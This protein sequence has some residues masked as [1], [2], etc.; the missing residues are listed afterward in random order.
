MMKPHAADHVI[1]VSEGRGFTA[2]VV[3]NMQTALFAIF[4]IAVCYRFFGDP[5]DTFSHVLQGWFNGTLQSHG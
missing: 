2:G 5:H 3:H 4:V 1:P